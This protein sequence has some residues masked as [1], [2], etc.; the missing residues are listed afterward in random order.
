MRVQDIKTYEPDNSIKMGFGGILGQIIRE[1]MDNRWLT[2]QLF[3]RDFSSLYKQSAVGVLWALII[4]IVSVSAFIV[5]NN[6]GIFSTGVMNVPY[7]IFA[8]LGISFWQLFS[9]GL[10]ACTNSLA[11]A[12]SMIKIISFSKKSLVIASAGRA[13]V[14]FGVQI[15]LMI[16]LFIWFRRMPHWGICLLPL[17]MLPLLILMI[18]LGFILSLLN[19]VMRDIGNAM[20]VLMTFVMFLTPVLYVKPQQGFLSR[21][22]QWNPLHYLISTPREFIL[23]G[24]FTDAREYFFSV[25]FSV[26]VFLFCSVIFHLTETKITE[27]V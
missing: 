4:P 13:I 21:M 7:P 10:I 16:A 25:L 9:A 19:A 3:K 18:G 11:E 15:I 24:Y 20:S 1:F 5:L 23:S 6:S 14:S 17:F 22:T 12:G 2:Y 26:V 27:R 8:V